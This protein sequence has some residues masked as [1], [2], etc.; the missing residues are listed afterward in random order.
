[1]N[2]MR[3]RFE[4]YSIKHRTVYVKDWTLTETET[5]KTL[6]G[7][8]ERQDFEEITEIAG[9]KYSGLLTLSTDWNH[10]LIKSIIKNDICDATVNYYFILLF[11]WYGTL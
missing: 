6:A 8:K 10:I 3:N 4:K 1:M 11:P 2:D 5:F 9:A 7:R